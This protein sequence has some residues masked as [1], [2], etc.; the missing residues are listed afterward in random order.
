MQSYNTL[1]NIRITDT[2]TGGKELDDM[3][4]TTYEIHTNMTHCSV[5]AW[6]KLFEKILRSQGFNEEVIMRGATQL[7]FND[8]RRE[9]MM[10]RLIAEY[11]L[12]GPVS[13]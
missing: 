5:H 12:N 4:E 8:C 9:E 2:N 3:N 7:A 13:N 10:D 11:E 1:V 6:F